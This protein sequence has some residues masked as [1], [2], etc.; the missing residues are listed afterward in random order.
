MKLRHPWLI[1]IAAFLAAKL[2]RVWIWT[3]RYQYDHL[4]PDVRPQAGEAG[5]TLYLHLLA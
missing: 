3:L 1:R 2:I 5:R 4:G